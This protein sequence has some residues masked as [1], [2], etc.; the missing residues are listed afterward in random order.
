MRNVRR[1]RMCVYLREINRMCCFRSKE[2]N[3]IDCSE[4]AFLRS[5]GS[6]IEMCFWCVRKRKNQS[7]LFGL[8]FL[9]SSPIETKVW[10][11]RN[12]FQVIHFSS[13]C[14]SFSTNFFLLFR[15]HSHRPVYLCFVQSKKGKAISNILPRILRQSMIIGYCTQWN[16]NVNNNW[17]SKPK[18]FS[19]SSRHHQL[20]GTQ[21]SVRFR[22]L[23]CAISAVPIFHVY[24]SAR[25]QDE[26]KSILFC[27]HFSMFYFTDRAVKGN[28]VL[29]ANHLIKFMSGWNVSQTR[30]IQIQRVSHMRMLCTLGW[31]STN[32]VHRFIF[33]SFNSV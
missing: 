16:V 19:R 28:E 30:L 3:K 6:V 4:D 8:Q 23:F 15:L 17:N 13:I 20:L 32:F 10:G 9:C 14:F 5:N 26:T 12:R 7:I 29:V 33:D 31:T 21:F 27:L 22:V 2:K 11:A 1:D 25:N 24:I 18:H